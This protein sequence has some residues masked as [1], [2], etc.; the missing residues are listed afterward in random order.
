MKLSFDNRV[1][2]HSNVLFVK[3]LPTYSVFV[4]SFQK[5]KKQDPDINYSSA[6]C[7][8]RVP[9]HSLLRIH[10]I[11]VWIRIRGSMPLLMDPDPDSH[12][13]PAIFV[14]TFKANKKNVKKVFLLFTF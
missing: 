2:C 4:R 8:N 7:S 5:S 14:V 9:V 3:I 13:D 10:E 12:P 1:T 6:R 11:L